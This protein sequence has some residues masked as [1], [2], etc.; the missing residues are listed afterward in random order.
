MNMKNDQVPEAF[1]SGFVCLV[2]RPNVGKS[3]LLNRLVG[4]PISITAARPQTTRNRIMGV[5]NGPGYQV[6]F[7]D[8]PG[9]HM[10]KSTLNQRMV[11]YATAS[12]VDADF[13]LVLVEARRNKGQALGA[14]EELVLQKVKEAG[15]RALLVVNKIDMVDD[16]ELLEALDYLSKQGDFE[17]VVPVS[18]QTGK[19]VPVLEGLILDRLVEGPQYFESDQITDQSEAMIV[20]ELV[21]Q[22]VFRRAREEVPYGTAVRVERM[23]DKAKT[24][25]I[26]ARI[27]V[28]RDS[29][30]GI[31]IG[32]Q[33]RML[34]AIGQSAREKVERLFG[35][36]VYL[37]LRVSV[38]DRWS[39]NPRRLADLGYPDV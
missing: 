30:K 14:E 19:N 36:K 5:K 8:T 16:G 27:Y 20:A 39:E 9:I 21:R 24:L 33:G 3:T 12:L 6:V 10:A 17:A 23:E 7:M 31:I 29:Q 1:R 11:K 34:K 13:V 4:K 26:Y 38:M 2:G 28:E 35:V 15:R 18:A 22:E 32:K 37:D 25:L